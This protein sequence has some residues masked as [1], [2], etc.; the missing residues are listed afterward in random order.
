MEPG[1]GGGF[2]PPLGKS[3]HLEDAHAAIEADRQH[4]ADFHRM[5]R[6]LFA[7]AVDADVTGL[8]ERGSGGAGLHHP[9]VPQPLIETLPLQISARSLFLTRFLEREPVPTSL[10]NA[11]VTPCGCPQAVPSA[12]PVLQMA[13]WDRPDDRA[14]AGRH[15]SPIDGAMARTRAFHARHVRARRNPA[16]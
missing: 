14:R 8:D 12:P 16:S 1:R 15:W 3:H 2:P 9:R 6:R 5:S 11:T 10:E 4:V 13:N 7:H